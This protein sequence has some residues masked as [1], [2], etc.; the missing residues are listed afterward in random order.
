M[1]IQTSDGVTHRVDQ[2]DNHSGCTLCELSFKWPTCDCADTF[3][4]DLVRAF[5][6]RA[7]IDCM[8]CVATAKELKRDE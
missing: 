3:V 4:R 2:S 7:E 1:N 5:L 6:V 8:A